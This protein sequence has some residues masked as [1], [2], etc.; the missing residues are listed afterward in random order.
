MQHKQAMNYL[1]YCSMYCYKFKQGYKTYN[2]AS[3]CQCYKEHAVM[4]S[5]NMLRLKVNVFGMLK[6]H[7]G[8]KTGIFYMIYH[9]M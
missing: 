1:P 8:H 9:G 6:E 2:V 5:E 3:L 4:H 7:S